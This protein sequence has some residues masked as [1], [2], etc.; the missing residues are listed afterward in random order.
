MRQHGRWTLVWSEEPPTSSAAMQRE[1]QIKRT[2]S[3]KRVRENLLNG[4]NPGSS[5]LIVWLEVRPDSE[6]GLEPISKPWRVL[7][8][9]SH[10]W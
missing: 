7:R 5:G 3:A 4:W 1:R 6:S 8:C 9:P 2:K 10:V